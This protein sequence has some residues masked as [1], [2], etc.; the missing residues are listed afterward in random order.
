M[1]LASVLA[2]FAGRCSVWSGAG[3]L[4]ADGWTSRGPRQRTFLA[5]Q[6]KRTG[7]QG[8]PERPSEASR[9]ATPL[10]AEERSYEPRA[11]PMSPAPRW[12]VRSVPNSTDHGSDGLQIR[13]DWRGSSRRAI[14]SRLVIGGETANL[15]ELLDVQCSRMSRIALLRRGRRGACQ[16]D[17]Y[18]AV[19]SALATGLCSLPRSQLRV[20]VKCAPMPALAK[21][22]PA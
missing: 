20:T 11:E 7:D 5:I 9:K 17:A 16:G 3:P 2:L 19:C 14:R 1:L 6:P 13:R 10:T 15:G 21:T 22:A 4:L 8:R 12:G 18:G